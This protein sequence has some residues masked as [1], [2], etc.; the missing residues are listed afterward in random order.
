[1]KKVANLA[2]LKT[3]STY[4]GPARKMYNEALVCKKE[5]SSV[6]VKHSVLFFTSTI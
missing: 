4:T 2:Q 5:I 6:F 3:D 1:M